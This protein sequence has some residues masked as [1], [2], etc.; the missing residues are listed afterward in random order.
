MERLSPQEWIALASPRLAR[1]WRR[2]NTEQLDEVA[3]DL[4]R[5]EKLRSL[6]PSAAVDNW[7]ALLDE[8]PAL[9]RV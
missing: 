2:V 1:R 6:A 5:D 4:Y 3:A 8:K 9:E 7:L